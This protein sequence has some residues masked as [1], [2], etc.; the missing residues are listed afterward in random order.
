MV[1]KVP[2]PVPSELNNFPECSRKN[3]TSKSGQPR[4]AKIEA[5]AAADLG[6]I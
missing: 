2:G 3:A 5:V 6:Y 1:F 4:G